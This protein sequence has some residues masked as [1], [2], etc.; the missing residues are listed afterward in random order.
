MPP[1]PPPNLQ[2]FTGPASVRAGTPRL[3]FDLSMRDSDSSPASVPPRIEEGPAETDSDSS[4]APISGYRGVNP[5]KERRRRFKQAERMRQKGREQALAKM[6]AKAHTPPGPPPRDSDTDDD[7]RQLAITERAADE[8]AAG[9]EGGRVEVTAG[10]YVQWR[11][12]HYFVQDIQ[13]SQGPE[14]A[15]VYLVAKRMYFDGPFPGLGYI[16]QVE[17]N[18]AQVYLPADE[19][20]KVNANAI[21]DDMLARAME[22]EDLLQAMEAD[23][24][25]PPYE[26]PEDHPAEY[27]SDIGDSAAEAAA[28]R[29]AAEARRAARKPAPKGRRKRFVVE[30]DTPTDEPPRRGPQRGPSK[31]TR[32]GPRA[33]A[34]AA[35]EA[36]RDR[37]EA[38]RDRSRSRG[39]RKRGKRRSPAPSASSANL[40]LK[41]R[42]PSPPKRAPRR[43]RSPSASSAQRRIKPPPQRRARR[44]SPADSDSSTKKILGRG[45]S[46]GG[47]SGG[48]AASGT[49]KLDM[50][51]GQ[52]GRL[53][54][55]LPALSVLDLVARTGGGATVMR[56]RH[57]HQDM[58]KLMKGQRP[59]SAP[60]AVLGDYKRLLKLAGLQADA[61]SPV[62]DNPEDLVA[63]L[64]M[65]V[66]TVKGGGRTK[67]ARR[68][69]V[70]VTNGLA[71][72][73]V[74][75]AEEKRELLRAYGPE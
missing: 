64:K 46:G 62:H 70:R 7:L 32:Q 13:Q 14:R 54:V 40:R 61:R 51:T 11:G 49:G 72:G 30:S 71:R 38:A 20:I 27:F 69:L 37:G 17:P 36:A 65:L 26:S 42:P 58:V 3:P 33:R 52:F 2:A 74:L 8:A 16:P 48:A 23:E 31:T 28:L 5:D 50:K 60:A 44:H 67:T 56:R 55:D 12:E 39:P 41:D 21:A 59:Q 45:K 75:S 10:D 34:E 57:V 4:G 22:D 19:V 6:R 73:G 24:P 1:P 35:R 66:D 29:Q 25:P 53:R 43:R 15:G 68:Q 9:P 63:R 18:A 47:K